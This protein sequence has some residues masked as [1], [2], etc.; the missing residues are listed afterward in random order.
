MK[1]KFEIGVVSFVHSAGWAVA[2]VIGLTK[3]AHL[4]GAQQVQFGLRGSE[5]RMRPAP[6]SE[7]RP[8]IG[9]QVPIF[10]LEDNGQQRLKAL[11]WCSM[12]Y[13]RKMEL[14][15]AKAAQTLARKAEEDAEAKRKRD[16]ARKVSSKPSK[17]K[18]QKGGKGKKHKAA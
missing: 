12:S 8:R 7:S 13:Y 14:A 6:F 16:D 5:L 4:H 9:E 3:E 18:E 2:Q 1:I 11:S 15:A 17:G 10:R